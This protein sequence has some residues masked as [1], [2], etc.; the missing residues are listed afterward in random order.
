ME[1]L[2]NK[3][4]N[5]QEEI[6]EILGFL[7]ADFSF[8]RMVTDIELNTPELIHFISEEVYLKIVEF[9]KTAS[10]TEAE[11][12]KFSDVLKKSQLF[13]LIMAYHDFAGNNDLM[14]TTGGRKM[15]AATDEKT[16]WDWQIATDNAALKK[17]AYKALD[18]LITAL[19]KS[20]L[21][22]WLESVAY[23]K[24]K[25]LFV[26]NTKIFNNR[27]SINNSEQLYFRLVP[28]MADIELV[29]ICSRIGEDLHTRLKASIV[30]ASDFAPLTVLEKSLKISIEKSIVYKTL[31][32]AYKMFPVEMFAEK[33]N[34]KESAK[35]QS[36]ARAEVV[37]Y[38]K[39]EATEQLKYIESIIRKIE[40]SKNETNETTPI[41]LTPG[42]EPETKHVDL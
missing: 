18:Q 20:K 7:S 28:F 39:E 38:F 15:N 17:K 42:L 16:P 6:T 31:E 36:L 1:I 34:Y 33:I 13:I 11:Q 4:E 29:E 8:E 26:H 10:P 3:D 32:K 40:E 21:T 35:S 41:N 14:H 37:Q 30:P 5:G 9:Y 2:F 19:D 12:T 22:E 25:A 24:S 23:K 27:H